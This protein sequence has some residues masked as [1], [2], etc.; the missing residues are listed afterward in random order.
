MATEIIRGDTARSVSQRGVDTN[1]R[2]PA[3]SL[4]DE[5]HRDDTPGQGRIFTAA[6]VAVAATGGCAKARE[7]LC[8]PP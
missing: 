8:A 1:R 4:Q 3:P 6:P 2:N 5:V 7:R